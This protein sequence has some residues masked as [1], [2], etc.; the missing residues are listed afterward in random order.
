M[1]PANI[2]P[3]IASC[4]YDL[5][6]DIETDKED[7]WR[8]GIYIPSHRYEVDL[9]AYYR[10]TPEFVEMLLRAFE[11]LYDTLREDYLLRL[12]AEHVGGQ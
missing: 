5:Q 6:R 8:D 7:F 9:K 10:Q 1:V 3:Q 11:P 12:L 4:F 2:D